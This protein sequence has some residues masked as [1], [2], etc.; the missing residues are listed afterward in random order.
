M[1]FLISGY[2][3]HVRLA[4]IQRQVLQHTKNYS[5]PSDDLI[6]T[7]DTLTFQSDNYT[8]DPEKNPKLFQLQTGDI[9]LIAENGVASLIYSNS[10]KE[11]TVFL[12]GH[13]N[14]NCL[15]CPMTENERTK[16]DD[17]EEDFLLQYLDLL[18]ESVNHLVVTGGEPT[19]RKAIFLKVMQK[20][21]ERFPGTEVLLLTNGRSFSNPTFLQEFIQVAP[22]E[23]C[24]AI[25]LH[26][27]TADLHDAITRASGSYD[28]TTRAICNLLKK[29]QRVE[30]RIVVS[31][32]NVFAIKKLTKMICEQFS[33]VYTVNFIGLETRGNCAVNFKQTYIDPLTSFRAIRDSIL[34]LLLHGIS[35]SL[36]NFPLCAVEPGYWNLCKKSISP[37]K[38]RFPK[39]CSLCIYKNNCGGFFQTTLQMGKFHVRPIQNRGTL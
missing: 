11:A 5:F 33:T 24:F 28:Q 8:L 25:P 26:G 39:E 20:I 16:Q 32:L 19:V 4:C 7:K 10:E 37:E 18:P 21:S 13:C 23:L 27:P 9:L 3:S 17:I 1:N 38:I 12:T 30:I 34:Q 2:H 22:P 15:M 31:H 14:S 36:Y 35:A 6:I 29:R